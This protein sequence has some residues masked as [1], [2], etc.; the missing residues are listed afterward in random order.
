MTGRRHRLASGKWP[1]PL[2][3]GARMRRVF[4]WMTMPP[5]DTIDLVS[6]AD[7]PK[8][9]K[10]QPDLETFCREVFL[11]PLNPFWAKMKGITSLVAGK[12]ISEG[13]FSDARAN[14]QIAA[15]VKKNHYQGILCFSHAHDLPYRAFAPV[16]LG[17]KINHQFDASIFV[18]ER[19]TDLFKTFNRGHQNI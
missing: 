12:S 17:K 4:M 18:S 6:F 5:W 19:E 15:L 13:Y 1:K 2:P 3:T 8:D 7:D 10:H 16:V 14:S 9:L 11:F